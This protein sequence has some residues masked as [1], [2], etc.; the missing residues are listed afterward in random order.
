MAEIKTSF[1]PKKSLG[2]APTK[3]GSRPVGL[4]ML[5]AILLFVTAA[6]V[7]GGA[8][9]YEKQIE[10]SIKGKQEQL[11]KAEAAF[12]P[13]LL[14]LLDR[15]ASKIDIIQG[16]QGSNGGGLLGRHVTLIPLFGYLES[17]TLPTVRFK[18]LQYNLQSDGTAKIKMSGLARDYSSVALQSAEYTRR[19]A[20]QYFREIVF[21]DLNLDPLGSVTFNF[22]ATVVPELLSYHEAVKLQSQVNL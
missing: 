12:D 18:N 21:T 6:L 1:I 14:E 9:L 20:P 11:K 7:H 5:L 15:L 4:L 17:T 13:G 10:L 2:P 16:S 3:A 22:S 19:D 8:F